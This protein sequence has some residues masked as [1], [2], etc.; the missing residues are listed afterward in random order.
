MLKDRLVY[1]QILAISPARNML[2]FHALHLVCGIVLFAKVPYVP[3]LMPLAS[4]AG[5]GSDLTS[6][7]TAFDPPVWN[8]FIKCVRTPPPI[9]KA[10]PPARLLTILTRFQKMVVV[11]RAPSIAPTLL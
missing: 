6:S 2:E 7:S 10:A 3:S 11:S 4:S 5:S 8:D 1:C 9:P